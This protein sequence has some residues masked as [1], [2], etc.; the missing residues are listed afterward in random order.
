MPLTFD[1]PYEQLISYP[2]RY[3]R[4]HDFDL[5]WDQGISEALALDPQPTLSLDSFQTD[6]AECNHLFFTGVGGARIHAQFIRPTQASGPHPALLMFHG[7]SNRAGDW[8]GKL[9]YAAAGFSVAAMDCRGQGG[10]SEDTGGSTGNTLCGHIIRG[11][12]GPP[13]KMLF[14]Q[15]FLDTLILARIVMGMP[16]VDESRV[17]VMG[18]SQGGGLS[19]ACAALEPR[20]RRTAP[21]FPFLC[22]YQRV[23]ELDLAQDAYQELRDYFRLFDPRHE[24]QETIFTKLGYI[25]VQHLCRRI[26]GEVFMGMGLADT[27]CPPS[28]QFAA[29][30]KIQSMKSLAIYPDF[31]HEDLPGH[32]DAVFQFM[33]CLKSDPSLI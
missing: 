29:Y 25:D 19:L 12:D 20:I 18:G 32:S 33:Q 31:G 4:P 17:G 21:V 14:R 7:Y 2:G 5:F 10:L 1:M 15:I 6:F 30:N 8:T 16:E 22:D 27:I 3:P 13:E 11:L 26:Q 23:W 9:A 24:R 28:T